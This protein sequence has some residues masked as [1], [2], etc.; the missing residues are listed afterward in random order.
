MRVETCE[1]LA[2]RGIL[3][4]LAITVEETVLGRNSV[5]E[6]VLNAY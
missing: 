2:D 5:E 3:L 6:K 4:L 1:P